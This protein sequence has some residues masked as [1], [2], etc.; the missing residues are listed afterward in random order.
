M[1]ALGCPACG[2]S[3]ETI[4]CPACGTK[5]RRVPYPLLTV[6]CIA[7]DAAGRVL[8]V[9]RR[10]AP[11]GWA[12]PGG[13]VDVGETLEEAMTREVLE[14][15]GLRPENF[16]QFRAYSD[17]ARDHRHHIITVVFSGCVSGTPRAADD[18]A[19]ARFFA[20]DGLPT[21]M[22]ADHGKILADFAAALETGGPRGSDGPPRT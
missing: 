3:L 14:E 11:L 6:D 22:A 19:D 7:R 15:T 1:K 21:P 2:L 8:L 20:L 5:L 9:Q 16:E 13:F 17:P 10:F 4:A 12:L 18:A